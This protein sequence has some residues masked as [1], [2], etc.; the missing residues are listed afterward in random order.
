MRQS[1][2]QLDYLGLQS[3]DLPKNDSLDYDNEEVG[4]ETAKE[5]ATRSCRISPCPWSTH[6]LRLLSIP[7]LIVIVGALTS[8]AFMSVGILNALQDQQDSFTKGAN[9]VIRR[10]T[11][12]W[13]DYVNAASWIHGRCRDQRLNLTRTEFREMYEYL[14]AS[15]LDF[16]AAQFDPNITREERPLEEEKARQFYAQYYPHVDYRGFVGFNHDNSTSLDPRLEHDFY[17]PIRRFAKSH[18][19]SFY[20]HTT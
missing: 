19:V 10:F 3:M 11:R 1:I 9:N 17:F 2:T 16:Q 20:L 5:R 8:A 18:C 7:L 14:V 13:E 4:D 12:Y 15:G 6:S